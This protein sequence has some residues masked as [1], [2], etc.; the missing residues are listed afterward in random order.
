[1]QDKKIDLGKEIIKTGGKVAGIPGVELIIMFVQHFLDK[2]LKKRFAKFISDAEV[3]MEM[4]DK[5]LKNETYSNCFYAILE[6]VRQTHSKLGVVALALIYKDHWND[7]S[8]LIAA[9]RSFSQISD[10]VIEAFIILYESIPNE[11][12]YLNLR[13]HKDKVGYFHELYN[14]AVE[15]ISRNFFVTST[16]ACMQANAPVQG[17]KWEHTDSYYQYCKAARNLIY[18]YNSKDT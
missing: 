15:L 6:T 16:G 4:I 5:I 2:H 9:I 17:M 8:Y 13:N 18:T 11:K 7:E 14:E 10:K 1:M 3:D 12:N